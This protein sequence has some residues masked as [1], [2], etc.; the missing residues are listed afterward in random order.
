MNERW[1]PIDTCPRELMRALLFWPAYRLDDDGQLTEELYG[2]G[3]VGIAHRTIP[4]HAWE[5]VEPELAATGGYFGDDYEFGEPTHWR[6]VPN[7]PHEV[8]DE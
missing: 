6:P 7:G 3:L 2:K 5:E 8:G 4:G 1:K